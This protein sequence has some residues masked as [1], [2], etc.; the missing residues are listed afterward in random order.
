[1]EIRIRNESELLEREILIGSV[2]GRHDLDFVLGGIRHSLHKLE[3]FVAAG[4]ALFAIRYALPPISRSSKLY[5]MSWAELAPIA[6][7][8]AEYLIADPVSFEPS[9]EDNYRGSTL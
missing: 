2:L 8:V 5:E 6:H 1:M 7:L 4:I 3:P 9:V